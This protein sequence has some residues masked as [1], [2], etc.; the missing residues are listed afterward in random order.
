MSA[1]PAASSFSGAEGSEGVRG[2]TSR[3]ARAKSPLAIA[4]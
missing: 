4:A 1:W 2:R 3:P